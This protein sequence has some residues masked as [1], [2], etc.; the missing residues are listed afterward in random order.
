[1]EKGGLRMKDSG[2]QIIY[3][4]LKVEGRGLWMKELLGRIDD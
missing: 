1:M 4:E 3:G 2:W